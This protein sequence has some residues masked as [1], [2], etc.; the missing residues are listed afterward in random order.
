MS[1]ARRR[2][3]NPDRAF[4]SAKTAPASGTPLALVYLESY[5]EGKANRKLAT[6]AL[7]GCSTRTAGRIAS[8]T[9]AYTA[10]MKMEWVYRI[11]AVVGKPMGDILG[12]RNPKEW[13][14]CIIGWNHARNAAEGIQFATDCALAIVYKAYTG[15]SL[16]GGFTVSY[17]G[18]FPSDVT[19][20]LSPAP[21]MSVNKGRFGLHRIIV[22]SERTSPDNR[23]RMFVQH[24]DPVDDLQDK[25]FLTVKYLEQILKYI[26][27]ITKHLPA[28]LQREAARSAA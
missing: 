6:A 27:G 10:G 4:D 16:T 7:L 26:Y 19:I 25:N 12:S 23:K 22:T 18:G 24:I 2:V 14:D 3:E 11:C 5:L 17:H 13:G 1:H 20:F 28:E 15:F 9:T 8:R 21:E